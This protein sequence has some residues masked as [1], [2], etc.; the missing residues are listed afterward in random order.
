[1]TVEKGRAWGTPGPLPD[2]AVVVH[3]DA[4][5]RQVLEDARRTHRPFPALG[6]LGGDLCRTLGGTGD[7]ARLQSDAAMRFSVDL[8]EALLDG[9]LHDDRRHSNSMVAYQLS[10]N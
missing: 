1:M 3:S 6:L 9:R 2:D 8:G 5:A 7:A 10:C 4:E